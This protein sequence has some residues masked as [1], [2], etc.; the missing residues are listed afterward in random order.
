MAL[1]RGHSPRIRA[2]PQHCRMTTAPAGQTKSTK[3]LV[4][5]E[6]PKSGHSGPDLLHQTAKLFKL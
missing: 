4:N 3:F 1:R 5:L 6:F 2:W